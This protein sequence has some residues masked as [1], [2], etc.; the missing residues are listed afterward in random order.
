[1]SNLPDDMQCDRYENDSRSPFHDEPI[2]QCSICG[3]SF[4]SS[5]MVEDECFY[6]VE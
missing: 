4:E 1:M 5:E 6:C 3:G 2:M